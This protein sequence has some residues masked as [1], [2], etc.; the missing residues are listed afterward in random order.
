[1]IDKNE[2][3]LDGY[4]KDICNVGD[5]AKKFEQFD[6]YAQDVDGHDVMAIAEAIENAKKQNEK[7][8][9]IV[10]HT[11][12]GK[13]CTFAEDVF[14]NHHMTFTQEQLDEANQHLDQLIA[15]LG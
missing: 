5:L 13:D 2:K 4:T 6:W 11:V 10:L 8:S 9:V 1:M 3:Q 15:E 14:Y 7:P 12:K